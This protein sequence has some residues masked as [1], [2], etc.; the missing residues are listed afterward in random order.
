[1]PH[2]ELPTPEL[3]ENY[4]NQEVFKPIP[5]LVDSD[6]IVIRD[7]VYEALMQTDTHI[8]GEGS[9]CLV[10]EL[11]DHPEKAIAYSLQNVYESFDDIRAK[12]S[13]YTHKIFNILFPKNFPKMHAVFVEDKNGNKGTIRELITDEGYGGRKINNSFSIVH[14]FF[15]TILSARPEMYFDSN[16]DNFALDEDGNEYFLDLINASDFGTGSIREVLSK[17]EQQIISYMSSK[18]FDQSD[19]VSV[20]RYI[21]RLTELENQENEKHQTR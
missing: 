14:D 2:L 20:S 9:E 13:F 17:H 5:F 16:D 8:L 21:G 11:P 1:M 12:T 6:G 18:R 3:P 4:Q 7:E 15:R 19:I 10:I